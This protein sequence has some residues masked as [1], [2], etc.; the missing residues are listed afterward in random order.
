MYEIRKISGE[1]VTE[2]LALATEVFLEFEAPDYKPEGIEV[3]RR[4]IQM[5]NLFQNVKA[6]SVQSMQHLMRAK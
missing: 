1:E 5:P 2:A 6:V 3:F 4:F